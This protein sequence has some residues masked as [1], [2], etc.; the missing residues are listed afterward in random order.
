[1]G[2]A[3]ALWDEGRPVAQ[4][5]GV[6]TFDCSLWADGDVSEVFNTG[7]MTRH[8]SCTAAIVCA[9]AAANLAVLRKLHAAA[10]IV[11]SLPNAVI[12]GCYFG[13]DPG[14]YTTPNTPGRDPACQAWWRFETGDGIEDIVNGNALT[15]VPEGQ[16]PI[17]NT[18]S[19]EGGSSQYLDGTIPNYMKRT[20]ALLSPN[21]PLKNGVTCNGNISMWVYPTSTSGTRTLFQKDNFAMYIG[22]AYAYVY[23]NGSA[24]LLDNCAITANN[25][26]HISLNFNSSYKL[27]HGRLFN[28]YNNQAYH[29]SRSL[30]ATFDNS[31]GDFRIGYGVDVG[32]PFIG[33][34][35]DVIVFNRRL[36]WQEMEL[37]QQQYFHGKVPI[38]QGA[39][40]FAKSSSHCQG[41]YEFEAQDGT[42]GTG[43]N[44]MTLGN[45][46]QIGKIIPL[47]NDQSFRCTTYGDNYGMSLPEAS[48]ASGYPLKSGDTVKTMT[49]CA[50]V[51]GRNIFFSGG[52]F[53][54]Q[55]V[56]T[57]HR[58]I[59]ILIDGSTFE[60]KV[61]WGYG[62]GT[63]TIAS[64][65]TVPENVACHVGV[66]IDGINKIVYFRVFNNYTG[67]VTE[68][69]QY[70]TNTLAASDTGIGRGVAIGGSGYGAG[71][72]GY[73]DQVAIFNTILST[74]QIDNI[75]KGIYV[76]PAALDLSCTAAIVSSVGQ[77]NL[78]LL[79][80]LNCSAV[81]ASAVANAMLNVLRKLASTAPVVS[82]VTA[83]MAVTRDM[84]CSGAI[85]TSVGDAMLAVLR[86][87]ASDAP[88]E[89]TVD[90]AFM[91]VA[92]AL[93][94]NAQIES[95]VADAMLN[96]LRKL[97]CQADMVT[98][99]WANK[100]SRV[101]IQE[102]GNIREWTP[103]F[104]LQ[105]GGLPNSTDGLPSGALWVDPNDDWKLKVVP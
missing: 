48:L 85:T 16:N 22:G 95:D 105:F 94:S 103:D 17:V 5:A 10:T 35:D 75:R 78:A 9:P 65:I 47:N 104:T 23:I 44:T 62:G 88:I 93:A 91:N 102:E 28:T 72:N 96:V 41:L 73:I 67:A 31:T 53:Y 64:G 83:A 45:C 4:I 74:S 57:Y 11:S 70:P 82:S 52:T 49:F 43:K 29:L 21:F 15:W 60:L 55:N 76:A 42:D 54:A 61:V 46:D 13:T 81:M 19:V 77:A 58:G 99:L 26:I 56:V 7:V 38:A 89:T 3:I 92:R 32:N 51:L 63:E 71:Y 100:A 84:V 101:L 1:M 87:L 30:A 18:F 6:N 80:K 27:V 12:R 14:D 66:T 37:I 68:S 40:E 39:T 50:W 8:L 36:T 98:A 79:R 69:T 86:K 97:S 33:Y 90:D 59:N 25:W 24:Q 2:S 20:D 34:I